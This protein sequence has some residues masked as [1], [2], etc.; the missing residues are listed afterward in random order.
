MK[1]QKDSRAQTK[2]LSL[3]NGRIIEFESQFYYIPD[4]AEVAK[5][6]RRWF[7]PGWVVKEMVRGGKIL[8]IF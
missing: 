8:N 3:Q 2:D 1:K 6:A 7:E 5:P 4:G